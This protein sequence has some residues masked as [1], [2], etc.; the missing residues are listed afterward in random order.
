MA[1]FSDVGLDNRLAEALRRVNFIVPTEVQERTIPVALQGKDLI[2]R[3]K[4]GTGKTF[5][6]ILP[7][8]QM[9]KMGTEVEA[10]IIVP[11]RELALQVV[12]MAKKLSSE[13]KRGI[14]A[15]YG[16][17][18]INV[19][20][21]ELA[22]NPGIVV[23]TPGR[24]IDLTDR[25]ALS[26]EKVRFLVIDEADTMLEMGFISD[27][28]YLLS[29]TSDKRQT[30]L[31]SATM[32]NRIVDI[33]RKYMNQPVMIKVG[34]EDELVVTTIK[35]YYSVADNSM[36]FATLLKYIKQYNPKK[37]II[38]AKTKYAAD[39]LYKNMRSQGLEV[40][41]MHGGL[42]QA[43]REHSLREFK[44][45]AKF[46]IAT[47]VVARGIDIADISNII[48]FD[49]PD[50]PHTYIHR[51]GRSARMNADG[52][53]FSIVTREQRDL[54][55]AIESDA[56][57][58]MEKLDI[59]GSEFRHIKLFSRGDTHR[60]YGPG[61]DSGRRYGDRG[62]RRSTRGR[63]G[64]YGDHRSDRGSSQS[65]GGGHYRGNQRGGH[66]GYRRPRH[67]R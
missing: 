38:F 17:A 24:L 11:T 62:A 44:N 21:H 25:G 35:H 53:S 16:G 41:L 56:N 47:N 58:E 36:K 66:S 43:R 60:D 54:I 14:V 48:N 51:V 5:A 27:I 18:S 64:S 40:I 33:A 45:G 49:V 8:L 39:M 12:E 61:R 50:D 4:T 37:A 13:H 30:M 3:A 1:S 6:F 57:I 34:E 52:I 19:Q 32:P 23:G 65:G 26:I 9:I 63:G 28:E 2:A 42:T 31:F 55:R 20:M 15:A 67:N 29:M 10:L 22:R 46:L 7:I 59:D